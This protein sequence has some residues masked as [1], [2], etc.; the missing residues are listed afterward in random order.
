MTQRERDL[1]GEMNTGFE[2]HILT[3]AVINAD[4][5]ELRQFLEGVGCAVLEWV[6]DIIETQRCKSEHYVQR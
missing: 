6:R 3:N 1:F 4:Y 2:N 5:I